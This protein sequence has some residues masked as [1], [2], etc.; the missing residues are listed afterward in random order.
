MAAYHN[1]NPRKQYQLEI[2]IQEIY[3]DQQFQKIID[4]QQ[5]FC[6]AYNTIYRFKLTVSS[7][8]GDAK[9]HYIFPLS[10]LYLTVLHLEFNTIVPGLHWKVTH[11]K[12]A[13]D[14]N[15]V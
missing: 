7:F 9:D 11:S 14:L 6:N 5:P 3:F 1:G 8:V 15:S 10:Y 13:A 12:K 2:R 4:H